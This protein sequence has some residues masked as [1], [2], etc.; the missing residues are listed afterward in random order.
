[1]SRQYNFSNI[2]KLITR[3]VLNHKSETASS[4]EIKEPLRLLLVPV[5][6]EGGKAGSSSS[7]V[8]GVAHYL[9]PSGVRIKLDKSKIRLGIIH[10]TY[11]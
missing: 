10:T 6:L 9:F 3:H 11:E 4:I 2:S 7:S 5:S 1:M 8:T